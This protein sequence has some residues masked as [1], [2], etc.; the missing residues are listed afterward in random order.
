M[1]EIAVPP[2]VIDRVMSADVISDFR[3]ALPL[4][5]LFNVL[6]PLANLI[7][8]WRGSGFNLIARPNFQNHNDIFLELNLTSET[9][10]FTQ[11]PGNIPNRGGAQNDINLF[12]L[13][14]MQK[15]SDATTGGGL[16]VEPGI[17]VNVPQTTHPAEGPMV[18]RMASIPHGNAILVQGKSSTVAGPPNFAPA[19]TVPFGVGGPVPA[20][21]ATNGF[22]EY[23]LGVANPFRTS[24]LPAGITQ[25]MVTNP[26]SVLASAIA[27]QTIVSTTTLSVATPAQQGAGIAGGVENI[28]FL[29][30][31][32]Q[33]AQ[34][35]S[36][37]WIETVKSPSGG[38]LLQLQYSQTVLLNFLGLSWPHVTV[39]TL[40][41]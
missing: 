20:S 3:P 40:L 39:G 19:N 22:P 32:A 33:V 37:F 15:I 2:Q 14:Y 11:I 28:S 9:M 35:S 17:W 29:E 4:P 8:C 25:A 13:T 21:G 6:G 18:T 16:H 30:T 38:Q 24:P 31:N 10:D 26:N 7:G 36:T 12:G 1:A 5:T 41:Q 23:N 27:H 34:V